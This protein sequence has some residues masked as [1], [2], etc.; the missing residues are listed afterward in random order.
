V[1]IHDHGPV[2]PTADAVPALQRPV[3]GADLT[4]IPLEAPHEPLTWDGGAT[5][6]EALPEVELAPLV[7]PTEFD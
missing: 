2:S 7:V 6:L 4:A 5:V 1:H 3:I